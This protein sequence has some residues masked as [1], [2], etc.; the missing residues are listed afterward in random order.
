MVKQLHEFHSNLGEIDLLQFST[1][2]YIP[3]A[4]HPEVPEPNA[5]VLDFPVGKVGV[6]TRFFEF[7]NHRVPLSIF[8]C[9]ILKLLL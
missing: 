5:T 2:Y 6:Y 1:D 4:V 7:A 9:D 8:L 3:F